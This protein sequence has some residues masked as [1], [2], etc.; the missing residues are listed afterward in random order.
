MT[1]RTLGVVLVLCAAP[2]VSRAAGSG[3]HGRV[4]DPSDLP[5]PGVVMTLSS[6]SENGTDAQ[7]IASDVTDRNGEYTFD[8]PAGQYALTA[9]LSGFETARRDVVVQNDIATIDVGLS[10][11][12]FHDSVTITAQSTPPSLLAPPEPNAP[13]TVSRTVINAAML[14]NS[15]YEDV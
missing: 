7:T 15:R 13:V 3:V 10:L 5:L 6:P 2:G 9:E 1:L 12:A 4:T 14:P 8:V 11:A